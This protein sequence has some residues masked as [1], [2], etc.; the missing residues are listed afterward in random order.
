MQQGHGNVVVVKKTTMRDHFLEARS[1]VFFIDHQM[2]QRHLT[3]YI[4]FDSPS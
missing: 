4:T 3:A 1:M 2:L